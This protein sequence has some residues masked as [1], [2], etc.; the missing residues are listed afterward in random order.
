MSVDLICYGISSSIVYQFLSVVSFTQNKA[1]L[2]VTYN[3]QTNLLHITDKIFC[4]NCI[5]FFN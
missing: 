4:D 2:N 1:V 5:T 3:C